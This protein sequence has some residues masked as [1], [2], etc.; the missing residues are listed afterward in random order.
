MSKSLPHD[1]ITPFGEDTAKKEQIAKMFDD[2]A[3][4]YDLMNRVLS[5]GIDIGWRKK[6]INILKKDSPQ[7]IL[8]VACGTGDMSIMAAKMLKPAKITGIDI[9]AQML[10]V[11][12]NKIEK[13]GLTKIIELQTGDS[14]TI[15]FP[16]NSFDAITVAFGVRNFETLTNGLKEMLRVL[17][18]GGQLVVLEF[19]K[20]KNTAIRK[21]Y[22]LY[23]GLVAPKMAGLFSQDKKAYKYLNE[24][25]KAF[26]D[27]QLFTQILDKV[28]YSDTS[29]KTLSLG[30][31]CIYTGRK[32]HDK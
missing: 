14:E 4:R 17:R 24:S 5:A 9:S 20:P 22:N 12:K 18:P 2:I 30:I 25:A 27:G 8:D 13:E 1:H 21:L 23:M 32:P 16:H 15:N 26:P 11:G 3:P 10:A 6:A 7:Q 28:G 31:C 29:Y 19:S